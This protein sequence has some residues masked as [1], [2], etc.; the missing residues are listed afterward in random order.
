[1]E[2]T[3]KDNDK[4]YTREY[5]VKMGKIGGKTTKKKYGTSHYSKIR[6]PKSGRK[7]IDK[8]VV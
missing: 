3:T 2:T 5:F 6:S 8:G 7:P 1:M 4:V